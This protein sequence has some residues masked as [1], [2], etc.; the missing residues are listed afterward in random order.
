MRPALNEHV[1]YI[2]FQLLRNARLEMY[3]YTH[4][5][6]WSGGTHHFPVSEKNAL[7]TA[8]IALL[9]WGEFGEYFTSEW[10]SSDLRFGCLQLSPLYMP[11]ER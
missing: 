8:V 2:H 1:S 6:F 7:I 9:I 5:V 3:V 11:S 4:S 10:S